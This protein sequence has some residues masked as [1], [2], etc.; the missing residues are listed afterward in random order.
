MG[1]ETTINLLASLHPNQTPMVR[2]K[3]K[4]HFIWDTRR[5]LHGQVLRA[6]YI[7]SYPYAFA[8]GTSGTLVTALQN[9]TRSSIT[10]SSFTGISWHFG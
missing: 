9:N 5:D 10:G 1:R 6:G 7:K 8:S 2:Y 3:R 4:S